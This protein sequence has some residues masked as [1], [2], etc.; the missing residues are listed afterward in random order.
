MT[1]SDRIRVEFEREAIPHL[2]ALY[3]LAL[4]LTG[5]DQSRSEDLVQDAILKAYRSWDR[6]ETGTN[7]RAWLMTILRNTFIN[8]FRRVKSRPTDVEF[9]EVADRLPADTL[10]EADPEGQVFE[11]IIDDQVIAAIEELPDDFRI[12]IVLSDIEGLAYQEIADLLEIPIGTVKSRLFRA[13]KRL[14][15]RLY[16]YAVEMGF[17]R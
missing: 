11:R 16:E 3:G 7:C 12:S 17:L 9:E 14:Q 10:F 4:R 2:D 15:V 1:R 13:R 6:F 8:E 5:G